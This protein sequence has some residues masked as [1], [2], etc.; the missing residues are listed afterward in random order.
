LAIEPARE[1]LI[2]VRAASRQIAANKSANGKRW[3]TR[4]KSMTGREYGGISAGREASESDERALI[5]RD[6][7]PIPGRPTPSDLLLCPTKIKVGSS[8]Q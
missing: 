3:D 5:R 6:P 4:E 1:P 2:F 8:C 7:G